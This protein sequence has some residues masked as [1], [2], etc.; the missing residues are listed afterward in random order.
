LVALSGQTTFLVGGLILLGL[1]ERNRPI[2]CG[3]LFAL[4]ACIKPQLLVLL[5]F[6][7][8]AEGR[9]R[10][11]IATALV[12]AALLSLSALIWGGGLWLDW[13]KAA[14]GFEALML[15]DPSLTRIGI[16]PHMALIRNGLNGNWSLALIP[17]VSVGTWLMFRRTTRLAARLVM[18]V[19]GALL[20]SPY[21]AKYDLALLAP[22]MVLLLREEN[23]FPVKF[24]AAVLFAF[25]VP[26]FASFAL[27][28]PFVALAYKPVR[29]KQYAI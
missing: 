22:A 1:T 24:A 29:A 28:A 16:T 13:I 14:S 26:V 11:F 15:S 17:V 20:I 9:W 23:G 25:A 6:A 7:L 21:V 10:T 2:L 4:A 5:P 18:L 3:A 12:G 19:G 27:I 8:A